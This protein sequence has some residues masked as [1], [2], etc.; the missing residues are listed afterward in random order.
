MTQIPEKTL[1]LF[2]FDGTLT[3]GDSFGR[4]LLFACGWKLV[5]VAMPRLC[6]RLLSLLFKGKWSNAA[7]K[8]H[9]WE[10]FFSGK[11]PAELDKL[12]CDFVEK[13]VDGQLQHKIIGDL[14]RYQSTGASVWIVSASLDVWL[15]PFAEREGVG[16]LCTEVEFAAGRATGRFSSPN[17]KGEE[18]AR[19]IRAAIDLSVFE[20]I[21]AYGN[22]GGD[23]AMFALAHEV[24][25]V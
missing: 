13:V 14:R 21:T 7:V 19:R 5:L 23:A 6:L 11:T 2:D 12:G 15:R 3:R 16:L 25:R 9:I 24:V 17:C 10:Y 4:F 20:H 1:V 8:M 18:K 22:S